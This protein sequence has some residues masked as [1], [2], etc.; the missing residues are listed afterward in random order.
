MASVRKNFRLEPHEKRHVVIPLRRRL[1][2]SAM[3]RACVFETGGAVA[4]RQR[5]LPQLVLQTDVIVA[6]EYSAVCDVDCARS[7]HDEHRHEI[8]SVL[9]HEAVGRI[10][11]CGAEV[12]RWSLGDRVCI[13]GLT[14][15]GQCEYCYAGM[16]AHCRR[17]GWMLGN[18]IDGTHA[19]YVR[20]PYADASLYAA[21]SGDDAAPILL[22]AEILPA[23][24][25]CGFPENRRRG[26]PLAIMGAGVCAAA[27]AVY[28]LAE[29]DGPV[30]CIDDHEGALRRLRESIP[31][32]TLSPR[33]PFARRKLRRLTPS[34][35]F[36][37][38]LYTRAGASLWKFTES[39]VADQG[40]VATVALHGRTDPLRL[41]QLW[42]R[43]VGVNM[44]LSNG[45]QT[46]HVLGMLRRDLPYAGALLD[47]MVRYDYDAAVIACFRR[48]RRRSATKAVIYW[49]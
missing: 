35:R 15:C 31:V 27:A 28:A 10:V 17:G 48:D 24:A 32:A 6:V 23:I 3:M 43:G 1:A 39:I 4:M 18:S 22:A 9:G 12:R 21:P 19:E 16:R 5:P 13:S 41:E 47:R 45:T 14:A 30:V 40:T 2:P 37:N 34:G 38:V 25:E 26:E 7:T 42:A 20:V 8:A 46:E 29:G 36:D 11:A 49:R 33:D 44:G